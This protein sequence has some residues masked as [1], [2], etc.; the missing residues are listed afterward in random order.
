MFSGEGPGPEENK[1]FGGGD[2][3]P[4]LLRSGSKI[5]KAENDGFTCMNS[6]QSGLI[7]MSLLVAECIKS[8]S[9]IKY[10]TDEAMFE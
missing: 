5:F 7:C 1:T 2:N 3:K 6:E 10:G 9:D 4:L 8:A